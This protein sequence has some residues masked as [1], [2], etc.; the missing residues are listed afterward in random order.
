LKK[1]VG[2]IISLLLLMSMVACGGT[3]VSEVPTNGT[4]DVFLRLE[5]G[6]GKAT[7]EKNSTMTVVDGEKSVRLVWSSPNY[8]YMV[9]EGVKY[10]PVN[11]EG[12][13]VFE[14]PVIKLDQEYTVIADTVAMSK[15]HEIEYKLTVSLT[16]YENDNSKAEGE[17]KSTNNKNIISDS[18]ENERIK[19]WIS[20]NL[21]GKESYSVSYAKGFTIDKYDKNISIIC[22]NE[23]DFY[24]IDPSHVFDK[25]DLPEKLVPVNSVPENIYVVGTA[26]M[27]Y[28]VA[29][30]SL[31]NVRYSS[32]RE[33]DWY[34]PDVKNE[35]NDGE[36]LYAGKYSAP[37]Y[38]LLLSGGCDLIIENTMITHNPEVF[39]KLKSLGFPVMVDYSSYEDSILGRMEWIKLYG[40]LTGKS[41]LAEKVF[42]TQKDDIEGIN[43]QFEEKKTIGFFSFTTSSGAQVRKSEDYICNMIELAGGQYAFKNLIDKGTGSTVIQLEAF[44]DIAKDCD[45]LIYNGTIEGNIATKEDL[46]EK[47]ELI[48]N[49]KAYTNDEIYCTTGNF[50]QSSMELGE[51]TQDINKIINKD[52]DIKYLFKVE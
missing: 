7:V 37:D 26:S 24:I 25:A 5:G 6:S 8:D 20:N 32:L 51:I 9:V 48:K 22:I 33:T 29:I 16:D 11:T 2:I 1:I 30:Q 21:S 36:I 46:V 17:D 19:Q 18:S 31:G 27:D 52:K 15:P 13:S 44:Y 39:E 34:L 40:Y 38:E 35:M 12:N 43:L 14:I 49:C 23:N 42:D 4:I 47:F 50:Y 28:F 3:S 45:I 10:Y 41:E